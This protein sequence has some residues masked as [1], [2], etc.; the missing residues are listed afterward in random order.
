MLKREKT[1][2]RQRK[3][4]RSMAGSA[5]ILFESTDFGSGNYVFGSD[6]GKGRDGYPARQRLQEAR[7]YV[8]VESSTD[9]HAVLLQAP[10]RAIACAL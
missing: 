4:K 6:D 8:S 3:A 2:R 1:G 10:G 5:Q 7:P 9:T